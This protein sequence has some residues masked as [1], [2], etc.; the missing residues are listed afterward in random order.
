MSTASHATYRESFNMVLVFDTLVP[1]AR[2]N[3]YL[4]SRMYIYIYGVL[5]VT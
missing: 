5:F 1:F 4:L 2:F 3:S